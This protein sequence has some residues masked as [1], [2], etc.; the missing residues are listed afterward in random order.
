MR[1]DQLE[2]AI[3]AAC[4]IAED[5]ELLIF[6]SQA[7]LGSFPQ[8][9]E[10]LRS[11]IEV[12]IQ[13]KNNVDKTIDIDGALG[14]DSMFHQTHGFYVHGI[15]IEAATLPVGW[16]ERT[17]L[18]SHEYRTHGCIG[19]CPEAHDLAASKL[20]AYRDK[21]REFVAI[22]LHERLID[23][24]VLIERIYLLPVNEDMRNRLARWVRL[25]VEDLSAD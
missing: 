5:T 23:G 20:V 13:P 10:S 6:G 7:I 17:I 8:A 11:S 18:V 14:E 15:L 24:V 2:H 16:E 3:R 9:P 22:L 4:E 25:N 12:D 1:Y 21:D 19:Y